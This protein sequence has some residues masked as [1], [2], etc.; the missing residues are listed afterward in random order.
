MSLP[1][2]QVHLLD[3]GAAGVCQYL[4]AMGVDVDD[5]RMLAAAEAGAALASALIST[6]TLR[7]G[8]ERAAVTI[9]SLQ[10][11]FEE[12]RR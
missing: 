11:V 2:E 5:A 4:A 6:A 9:K 3:Q 10:A 12:L 8:A 7:G 1:P